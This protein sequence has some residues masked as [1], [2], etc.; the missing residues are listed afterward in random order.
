MIEERRH[1]PGLNDSEL[2][3]LVQFNP[4]HAKD[5]PSIADSGSKSLLGVLIGEF[6]VPASKT[7]FEI[8]QNYGFAI[9]VQKAD[10]REQGWLTSNLQ[11]ISDEFKRFDRDEPGR[12]KRVLPSFRILEIYFSER[13]DDSGGATFHGIKLGLTKQTSYP[14]KVW[15]LWHEIGHVFDK[16]QPENSDYITSNYCSSPANGPAL[17]AS[18]RLRRGKLKAFGDY[19]DFFSSPESPDEY[20]RKKN[21][22]LVSYFCEA[23]GLW[24]EALRQ[25]HYNRSPGEQ[26]A[27]DFA[28][29]VM[30][31]PRFFFHEK[32]V[33][34]ETFRFFETHLGGNYLGSYADIFKSTS[35][36]SI[37][38]RL[39]EFV[40]SIWPSY[41]QSGAAE[42]RAKVNFSFTNLK[43][44]MTDPIPD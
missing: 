36:Y 29:F 16:Q 25:S 3:A 15:I 42:N 30:Y 5:F 39:A 18:D 4:W 26:F 9:H 10:R 1:F 38:L 41:K 13:S 6:G 11:L 24:G 35:R 37:E 2:L 19:S 12:F 21:Y 8:F 20:R 17:R 22:Q 40:Q 44:A 14:A 7:I 31:P 32:M 23:D 28:H 33:A 27:D 43:S 34:P